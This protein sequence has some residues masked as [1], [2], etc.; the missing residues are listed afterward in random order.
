MNRNINEHMP[1]RL[2]R[3]LEREAPK[4]QSELKRVWKV[5][6]EHPP[7]PVEVP[8][9]HAAWGEL[10]EKIDAPADG[11]EPAPSY[12]HRSRRHARAPRRNRREGRHGWRRIAPLALVVIVGIGGLLWQLPVRVSAPP[13][14]HRVVVLPDGSTAQLNSGTTLTYR[15]SFSILPFVQARRRVVQ[16]HGEAFFHVQRAATRPFVV[17]TFN[18]RIAVLGTRFNVRADEHMH[19]THVTLVTGRVRVASQKPQDQPIVLSHPGESSRVRGLARAP[20]A[21]QPS[22]L[23]RVLSWRRDGFAVSNLPLEA[24]FARLEHRYDLQLTLHASA[25]AADSMTLY[26]PTRTSVETILHDIC[27]AK[28]LKYRSTSRG[29]EVYRATQK[30]GLPRAIR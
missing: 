1:R 8:D 26:Y 14:E 10:A 16:L 3:R 4:E 5:L 27:V 17:E 2:Q 11:A 6:G 25:A 12:Q 13:G 28:G 23:E 24:I 15:R 30:D 18:A 29:Y 9:T 19:Q 7:L 22:N 20:S 21:P